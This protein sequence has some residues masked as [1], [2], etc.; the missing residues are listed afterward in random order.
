M[1]TTPTGIPIETCATCGCEHPTTR[2]HCVECGSEA[3]AKPT[4]AE[5]HATTGTHHQAGPVR[6][7]P[8]GRKAIGF[9]HTPPTEKE[10]T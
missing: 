7:G 1:K 3:E 5:V 2:R 6:T 8:V 4:A 9:Q 10:T